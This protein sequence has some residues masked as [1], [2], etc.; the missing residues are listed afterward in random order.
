[1]KTLSIRYEGPLWCI[2]TTWRLGRHVVK[3]AF[4]IVVLR[5][6]DEARGGEVGAGRL[7]ARLKE[8]VLRL[9]C[10][11]KFATWDDKSWSPL[12]EPLLML[13]SAER[14]EDDSLDTK[15]GAVRVLWCKVVVGGMLG[16]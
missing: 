4:S 13:L 16:V 3:K 1:M 8:R 11:R 5:A 7:L 6:G 12:L 15:G 10:Y 2:R 9:A 14:L